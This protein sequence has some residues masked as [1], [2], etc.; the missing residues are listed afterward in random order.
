MDPRPKDPNP[1]NG[2]KDEQNW[3]GYHPARDARRI[4]AWRDRLYQPDRAVV[5]NRLGHP[6]VAVSWIEAGIPAVFSALLPGMKPWKGVDAGDP[7]FR[8]DALPPDRE[9]ARCQPRESDPA[10]VFVTDRLD[11]AIGI[12]IMERAVAR[13]S[14]VM[15]EFRK[16]CQFFG[17]FA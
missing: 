9:Q 3:R 13:P 11:R 4:R 16:M 15:A 14:P 2:E 17:L 7:L 12:N 1:R 8:E 10:E 5:V 6:G